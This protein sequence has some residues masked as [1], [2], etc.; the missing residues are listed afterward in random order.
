[1]TAAF[2]PTEE[3]VGKLR[4]TKCWKGK[5]KRVIYVPSVLLCSSGPVKMGYRGL[6]GLNFRYSISKEGIQPTYQLNLLKVVL[7]NRDELQR[8]Y[9]PKVEKKHSRVRTHQSVGDYQG[10]NSI[11]RKRSS[12]RGSLGDLG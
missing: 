1:M 4:P 10:S 11:D 9:L 7:K 2:D 8:V 12:K 3:M 5:R 6:Y